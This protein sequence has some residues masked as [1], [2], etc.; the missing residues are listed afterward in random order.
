MP[1]LLRPEPPRCRAVP[2]ELMRF[3]VHSL[4]DPKNPHMVDLMELAGNGFCSC[5][6]MECVGAPNFRDNG[7][8]I[9]EYGTPGEP[10]P[11]RTRCKHID[12]ALRRFTNDLLRHMSAQQNSRE[13]KASASS[14]RSFP[15]QPAAGAAS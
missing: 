14:G 1:A 11:M 6:D 8:V 13:A 7:G 9:V 5:K 2:G 15:R 12:L 4:S 3:R 10:D